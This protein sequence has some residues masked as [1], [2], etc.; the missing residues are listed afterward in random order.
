MGFLGGKL[1]PIILTFLLLFGA[2]GLY[3]QES[4]ITIE[5]A[6]QTRYYTHQDTEDE[7]V[8]FT[9]DVVILV[10]QGK[11]SSRI[12]ADQ[13]SF[14]RSQNL[15][16]A[17]GSVLL[18]RD[19]GN[20][21]PEQMTADSLLFNIDSQEGIF[22]S[23][24]V[25]QGNS[26][27]IQVDTDS[28][29]VASAELF[30]RDDSGTVAFKRGS[31]TF[32]E[33]PDPH[34]KI[35]AS[36]IWLL[37][38]NEFAFANALLYIGKVPVMYF[39]FFYYPK[40]EL[41]FNPVFGYDQRK[42]YSIQTSTYLIGRKKLGG[43]KDDDSFF[44]FL[45]SSTMY[46]QRREG[47]VLRNLEEKDM[48]SY[49]NT[50]KFMA[51]YYTNLGGM[52]GLE[53]IFA[54]QNEAISSLDFSMLLGFSRTLFPLSQGGIHVYIP[55]DETGR[56]VYNHSYFS[57]LALPFR[58]R[59]HFNM[60][61]SKPFSMNISLPVYSD[62]FF[63]NDF[64]NDRKETM[65]WFDFAL[66]GGAD[67]NILETTTSG[68]VS[69]FLWRITASISP[70]VS[71]TS[72]YLSRVSLSPGFDLN[73]YS[74]T[75]VSDLSASEAMVSP[76]RKTFYPGLIK[77][78]YLSGT[79]SG[80]IFV[81]PSSA[82][83]SSDSTEFSSN[84]IDKDRLHAPE[85][86][87][88]Q[89]SVAEEGS[90]EQKA[91]ETSLLETLPLPS[92]SVT[93][94]QIQQ[95][96][97]IDYQLSYLI[98]PT[99]SSEIGYTV[100]E[101]KKA[102]D[103]STINSTFFYLKVPVTVSSALGYRNNFFSV[104]NNLVFTPV[105]QKHPIYNTEQ[106]Q[107][108]IIKNDYAAQKLDLNSNNTLTL[109]P[110]VYNPLLSG[111]FLSWTPNLRVIR[112]DFVGTAEAPEWDY[113]L[114]EWNAETFTN[115]SLTVNVKSQ[116]GSFYQQLRITTMLPPLRESYDGTLTLGF[117][118]VTASLGTGVQQKTVDTR[119]WVF[120]PINQSLSVNLLNNRLTLS[121]HYRYNLENQYNDLLSLRV[122]GYNLT[123]AFTMRYMSGYEYDP[124]LGWK[125][126]PHQE[127]QA[128]SL[129]LV[130]NSGTGVKHNFWKNRISISPGL[131]AG[132][133][134][135]FVQ[136]T[137]SYFIFEPSIT[138]TIN[139]FLDLTFKSSSRN[140]VIYRYIQNFTG[141]E[142]R[143]PGETNVLKDLWNSFCFWDKGKRESSGFKLKSLEV[144][145]NHQLHD[146]TLSSQFK[147]SPR[148]ITE[149]NKKV[150]DFS[151]H[152]TL[153][154]VWKPMNSMK[155]T[156]EDKY[157]TVTLNP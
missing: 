129:E 142:P 68:E 28:R 71:R 42:G 131:N 45:N 110:F 12:R 57:G 154:V 127:F 139:E 36:R 40:D 43:K 18:N 140:D 157:G 31:L 151:P 101:T 84:N 141:F 133:H 58:Y 19:T 107:S 78:F 100:P 113:K 79:I 149:G 90:L 23:G 147:I 150:F 70:S 132:I 138:F 34:W 5:Q 134:Y 98:T 32:C 51:D 62:P 14:N 135:N 30:S 118:Y 145:L 114:P 47:L 10:V 91:S 156:I 89:Q 48:E 35:K 153:S 15:L 88:A 105:Y 39:P 29:L 49:P 6:R 1:R 72:P 60:T 126:K 143:I 82:R 46:K 52:V 119:E 26:G 148:I 95:V 21:E 86:F 103:W 123:M 65:D 124:V 130:Y 56:T 16:Y 54:P 81:Y 27:T 116:E 96:E 13:V 152:F 80:D 3:A 108:T 106:L 125:L 112:S 99:I 76:S 61:V 111:T 66:S 74:M 2:L 144:S 8:V 63:N 128:S 50:L 155:T 24:T 93:K 9:G 146:W 97:G 92:I 64:L 69:S 85:G 25:V 7:I 20:G 11:T 73:F 104:K 83:K 94:P 4:V 77:P 67:Q 41:L 53:G 137:S 109:S 37:P 122:S 55:Y 102:F 87:E 33:E 120:L 17:S 75:D 115:H 38:G 44:S 117:P 121:E 22:H 136:P 59:G